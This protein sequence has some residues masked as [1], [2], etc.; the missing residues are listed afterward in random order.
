MEP[1]STGRALSRATSTET[2]PHRGYVV[3]WRLAGRRVVVV[4]GGPVAEAKVTGLLGTGAEILVVAPEVVPR[5]EHLAAAEAVT[6]VARRVRRR[7]L[8]RAAL[9]VAA[10]GTE[11]TNAWVCLHARRAGALVN[12]VDDPARCDVTVPAVVRRGPATVAVTTDGQSPAAA[13]FLREYL[14][15][16][17]PAEMGE[18]VAQA[19]SARARLRRQGR[20]RYDYYAWK[21]R[22][23]EPAVEAIA[24]GRG[25]GVLEELARRLVAGFQAPSPLRPGRISLVAGAGNDRPLAQRAVEVLAEADVV[26]YERG[27]PATVLD[28]APVAAVRLP[29]GAGSPA[30]GDAGDLG[31]TLSDHAGTGAAVVHLA[32]GPAPALDAAAPGVRVELVPRA[33]EPAEAPAR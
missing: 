25:P 11:R 30:G 3:S 20:Y 2:E 16:A 4:G 22:F 21:Q 18:M 14:S 12:A 26:V 5:L 28:L 10:T 23:F 9:V 17:L 32:T 19:A 31:R 27:V 29:A 7:D 33:S 8:R 15:A 13:R 1:A 6:W 24:A